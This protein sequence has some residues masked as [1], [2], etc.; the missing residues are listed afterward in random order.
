MK[1]TQ[2]QQE[3]MP[4]KIKKG[5]ASEEFKKGEKEIKEMSQKVANNPQVQAATQA[6]KDGVKK[7]ANTVAGIFGMGKD[8]ENT[9]PPNQ[10][11]GKRRRK[12][13]RKKRTKRRRK[14]RR[15]KR[16]TKRRRKSRRK[17]RR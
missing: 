12:S 6:A 15:K 14:S 13:R 17:T 5:S 16:R 10:F 4:L 1:F 9:P 3:S 2:E 8:T 11:G 7:A